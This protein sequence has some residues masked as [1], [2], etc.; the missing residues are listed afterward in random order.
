MGEQGRPS[1]AH[2][3]LKGVWFAG[4]FASQPATMMANPRK[5]GETEHFV[6][7]LIKGVPYCMHV[8]CKKEDEDD[9]SEAWRIVTERLFK[10]TYTGTL[11]IDGTNVGIDTEGQLYGRNLMMESGANTYQNTP[12][13]KV[14]GFDIKA[15]ETAIAAACDCAELPITLLT[16][17]GELMHQKKF[18]YKIEDVKAG[19]WVPFGACL[20]IKDNAGAVFAQQLLRAGFAVITVASDTSG[21]PTRL[22]L[23]CNLKFVETLQTIGFPEGEMPQIVVTGKTF[24]DI[25]FDEEVFELMIKP[26]KIEGICMVGE[27]PSRHGEDDGAVRKWLLKKWKT[28]SQPQPTN[29]KLIKHLIRQFVAVAGEKVDDSTEMA[30]TELLIKDKAGMIICKNQELLNFVELEGENRPLLFARMLVRMFAIVEQKNAV[31]IPN[32]AGAE[33]KESKSEKK[34]KKSELDVD[35]IYRQAVIS[36]Q[37]KF[38]SADVWCEKGAEGFQEYVDLIAEECY[39]DIVNEQGGVKFMQTI[40]R[41]KAADVEGKHWKKVAEVLGWNFTD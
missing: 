13:D 8:A 31:Q 38:D 29:E 11:K 24:V 33:K 28:G 26:E 7:Y 30:A 27:H 4:R 16:V 15:F 37:T 36:A 5:W 23:L 3:S 18:D 1:S 35:S 10:T 39:K 32:K 34:S 17:Y 25:I 2:C 9:L 22:K 41:C 14:K 12:L 40:L 20:D 21:F 6:E 19:V